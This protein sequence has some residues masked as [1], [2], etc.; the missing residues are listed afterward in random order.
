MR[1]V[2]EFLMTRRIV[3]YTLPGLFVADGSRKR[4][5]EATNSIVT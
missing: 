3:T 2:L 1:T 5:A 4:Y